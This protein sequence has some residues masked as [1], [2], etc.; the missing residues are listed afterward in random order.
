VNRYNQ[1][2]YI[3][4]A[5]N[6]A[7]SFGTWIDFLAILTL[8]AYAY[9]VSPYQMALVSAA[10]LLPG[11]I[12]SRY[13]GRLCDHRNPRSILLFSILCRVFATLGILFT[14]QYFAFV[15]LALCRLVWNL[16]AAPVYA[17]RTKGI[18]LQS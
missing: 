1:N 2:Q 18:I 5:G 16:T 17:S 10:G 11:I 9:H 7:S 13:I 12:T 8:A 15:I 4:L 6:G 3:L 14:H